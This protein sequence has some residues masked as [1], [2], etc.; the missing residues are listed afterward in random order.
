MLR[1]KLWIARLAGL[2]SPDGRH[3][4]RLPAEFRGTIAGPS[5]TIPVSGVDAHR[6]G[7]GVQSPEALP[8]GALVFLR[9]TSLG[10][11]GFAHVRHCSP[12]GAGYLLGLQ[13][14]D[15]LARE[16]KEPETWNWQQ[17]SQTGRRLWDEAEI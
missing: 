16:R 6:K 1:A 2:I 17:L 9:I 3:H 4:V 13:F 5:G 8:L 7:V 11:M 12:R 15:A 14:R 10:L